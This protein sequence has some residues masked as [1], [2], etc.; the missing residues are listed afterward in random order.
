MTNDYTNRSRTQLVG[1][2]AAGL[3]VAVLLAGGALLVG[4]AVLDGTTSSVPLPATDTPQTLDTRQGDGVELVAGVPWGFA[5][6]AGGAAAAA[7]AVITVTGQAE[8]AFDPDRFAVL[9]ERLFTPEEAAIQTRQVEAA[10]TNFEVSG[11]IDQ[12]ASRRMYHL[13]PLAVRLTDFD[14]DVPTAQV[15]VWAMTLV[16]IGDTG[17]AVFTTSTVDL[18]ADGTTGT[19]RVTA[20]DTVEGPVPL[21]Y[22]S[23]SAPGRTRQV[24]R[25]AIPMLPLPYPA[26]D[27]PTP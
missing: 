14:P 10:R 15:E 26:T 4:R 7:S 25:D 21:V 2:A 22:D 23:P 11:F 3:L 27:G 5:L 13:A 20:L 6:D 17:G 1:L 9:A 8:F 24:V 18:V 19:W 12:P 16:G